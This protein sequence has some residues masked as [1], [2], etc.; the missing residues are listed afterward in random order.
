[1]ARFTHI[2]ALDEGRDGGTH[3]APATEEDDRE[4]PWQR[5]AFWS[6]KK[7]DRQ[8]ISHGGNPPS[9]R[10]TTRLKRR[11][12]HPAEHGAR[13]ARALEPPGASASLGRF[14]LAHARQRTLLKNLRLAVPSEEPLLRRR[15]QG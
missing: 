3:L 12:N 8:R 4:E 9:R 11:R 15:V 14:I 1:M 10:G 6:P 2:R 7:R 5:H 13:E